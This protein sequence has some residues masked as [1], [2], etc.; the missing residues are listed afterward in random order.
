MMMTIAT[1]TV[2]MTMTKTPA[3]LFKKDKDIKVECSTASEQVPL[4]TDQ[5]TGT[6]VN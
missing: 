5:D 1:T 4:A 3:K 2:T 6:K